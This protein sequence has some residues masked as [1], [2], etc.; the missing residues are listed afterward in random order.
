MKI[1]NSFNLN[2]KGINPQ[3]DKNTSITTPQEE[4]IEVASPSLEILQAYKMAKIKKHDGKGIKNSTVT[5][6]YDSHQLIYTLKAPSN[7]TK[8][9]KII[10]TMPGEEKPREAFSVFKNIETGAFDIGIPVLNRV[11]NQIVPK[12]S[13]SGVEYFDETNQKIGEEIPE[14]MDV[15]PQK[16]MQIKENRIATINGKPSISEFDAISEGTS[17]GRL[18][19]MEYEDLIRY[20]GSEPIIA[21]IS[22]NDTNGMLEQIGDGTFNLPMNV[23]G[24][25]LSP[26]RYKQGGFL[27]DCL[28][29]AVSRLRGRKTFALLDKQTLQEIEKNHFKNSEKPFIKMELGKDKMKVTGLSELPKTQVS[30]VE[31]PEIEFVNDL[32]TSDD[33]RFTTKSVGLKAFNLGKLAEISTEGGYN[34]PPFFVVP[35]GVWD[36]AKKSEVNVNIYGNPNDELKQLGEYHYYAQKADA[37]ETPE[38]ELK[39]IRRLIAED[40]I[41]PKSIRRHLKEKVDETFNTEEL[42]KENGCLITRS[43]FN[44]EDSDT[45]AT[46]GLYDSFPGI[47]SAENLFKG[48]KLVWASKWSDLAYTSRRD[49][50]IEHKDIQ[51]NVIVQKVI[52]VD[53]TFTINTADPRSN[54]KNVIVAQLSQGVYSGFPNSPYIF[55]LN[56]EADT[57][58]RTT[59]ATKKRQK[60]IDKV[61][62][63]DIANCKYEHTDYSNDPL[64]MS[65]EEYAPIMRKVFEVAKFIEKNFGN[66]PQDIEGGIILKENPETGE[67]EPEIHIW[68]TRDE[69]L[70]E[71]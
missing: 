33:E 6:D 22:A 67:L 21:I 18:V 24:I 61:Q 14:K 13:I 45:M 55:E 48:I 57:I 32:L 10:Y 40:M 37:S 27:T 2:F 52:P 43:S 19:K 5:P 65:K 39:S 17:Y 50:N 38:V 56:K 3:T 34:V 69:H 44:G 71:R 58:T 1:G 25:L 64:N 68:Q 23:K 62:M 20:K 60:S 49:N 36:C 11:T 12:F 28:G 51:P 47:R 4:K 42:L 63:D 9:V 35:A 46:Q 26:E 54:D 8:Q 29:H 16:L 70:I 7:H 41:I 31:I 59:L 15:E 53:Y 30:K 66:K